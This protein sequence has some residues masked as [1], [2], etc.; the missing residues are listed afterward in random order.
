MKWKIQYRKKGDVNIKTE[1][2]D[3]HFEKK[4]D[5]KNWWLSKTS[6]FVDF[7][8]SKTVGG[9]R[10]DNEWVNCSKIGTK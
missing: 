4:N 9:S 8:G 5:V 7:L 10:Q 1:I 3:I 6:T 2:V